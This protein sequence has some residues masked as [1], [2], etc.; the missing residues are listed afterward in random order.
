[1]GAGTYETRFSAGGQGLFAQV[2]L[3][4]AYVVHRSAE[5]DD[6]EVPLAHGCAG[7]QSPH[8]RGC[9]NG[10]YSAQVGAHVMSCG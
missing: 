4:K 10:A 6:G 7:N 2:W 1:M 8:Q 9:Q 5:V 3:G